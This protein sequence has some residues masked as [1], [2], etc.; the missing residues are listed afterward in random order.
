VRK[1]AVYALGNI[2]TEAAQTAL[3]EVLAAEGGR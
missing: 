1:A 2:G 3:L